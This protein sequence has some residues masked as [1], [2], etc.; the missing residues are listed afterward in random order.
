ML[1]PTVALLRSE[2][3]TFKDWLCQL[4]GLDWM[5]LFPGPVWMDGNSPL[6]EEI[7]EV[8]GLL[9]H[10]GHSLEPQ[11]VWLE[12]A[13]PREACWVPVHT[14]HECKRWRVVFLCSAVLLPGLHLSIWFPELSTP[15]LALQECSPAPGQAV[16]PSPSGAWALCTWLSHDITQQ[17]RGKMSERLQLVQK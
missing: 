6:P 16:L 3:E 11:D 17:G 2:A 4:R 1:L 10:S 9:E 12:P 13:F 14:L 15:T 7:P 8:T 5:W